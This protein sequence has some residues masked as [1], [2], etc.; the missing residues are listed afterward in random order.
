MRALVPS[1]D[2]CMHMYLLHAIASE[3]VLDTLQARTRGLTR[4]AVSYVSTACVALLIFIMQMHCV[5]HTCYMFS[6]DSRCRLVNDAVRAAHAACCVNFSLNLTSPQS[7]KASCTEL[8][9]AYAGVSIRRA[10]RITGASTLH[11]A[12][13]VVLIHD[14]IMIHSACASVRTAGVPSSCGVARRKQQR[15]GIAKNDKNNGTSKPPTNQPS[16]T[17][18]A[19]EQHYKPVH[20]TSDAPHTSDSTPT[21]LTH[22]SQRTSAVSRKR[23]TLLQG[24]D[25]VLTTT[26]QPYCTRPCRHVKPST[27]TT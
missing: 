11:V 14:D 15:P 21:P 26:Q 27:I 9:L 2:K 22:K 18:T 23:P 7:R 4:Q 10:C 20:Q 13:Q 17:Q 8:F 16:H 19:N 1:Y 12:F 24:E 6:A 3:P 5:V 25:N